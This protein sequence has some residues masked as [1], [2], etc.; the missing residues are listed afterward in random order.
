MSPLKRQIDLHTPMVDLHQAEI[1]IRFLLAR[2]KLGTTEG[3][4]PP[5]YGEA[6]FT[7]I[8]IV[9]LCNLKDDPDRITP[10]G[11]NGLDCKSI[12]LIKKRVLWSAN[13]QQLL[14]I[15]H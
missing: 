14:Q 1:L 8:E 10:G 11:G 12:I 13:T 7:A 15:S 6:H 5:F 3:R 4:R 2:W 9:P